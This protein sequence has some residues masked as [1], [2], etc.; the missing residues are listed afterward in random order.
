MAKRCPYTVADIAR[1]AQTTE[2]TVRRDIAS[3]RLPSRK[4]ANGRRVFRFSDVRT[5]RCA[6]L[7]AK[8]HMKMEEFARFAGMSIRTL[9]RSIASG[10]FPLPLIRVSPRRHY[11]AKATVEMW[12]GCSLAEMNEILSQEQ[13][14]WKPDLL[15]PVPFFF[16]SHEVA[17][18]SGRTL[19][20]IYHDIEKGALPVCQAGRRGRLLFQRAAVE[21][22]VGYP[23]SAGRPYSRQRPDTR[24]QKLH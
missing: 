23:I 20:Q 6:H 14:A 16:L 12:L 8:P 10:L 5:Y 4:L 19:R 2:R 21:A 1:I 13:A 7:L 9:R 24:C 3:G 17:A 18:L 15:D 11:I 22:Y